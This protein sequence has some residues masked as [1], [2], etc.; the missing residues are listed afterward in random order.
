MK[1]IILLTRDLGKGDLPLGRVFQKF[2][3]CP[4]I[5]LLTPSEKLAFTYAVVRDAV[6]QKDLRTYEKQGKRAIS[7]RAFY[8]D[9]CTESEDLPAFF[10]AREKDGQWTQIHSSPQTLRQVEPLLPS[11][12][13]QQ[14]IFEGC[15]AGQF[16]CHLLCL[17]DD[18]QQELLESLTD[19]QNYPNDWPMTAHYL[20]RQLEKQAEQKRQLQET[21]YHFSAHHWDKGSEADWV[22]KLMSQQPLTPET[23]A[24]YLDYLDLKMQLL[25]YAQGYEADRARVY[26]WLLHQGKELVPA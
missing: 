8:Q 13:V 24:F 18:L 12:S 6:G 19:R 15:R 17:C 16:P 22:R 3:D 25:S 11:Q 23:E 9:L 4:V 7:P 5:R 10:M 26:Q 21:F 14:T 1:P 20:N 2:P